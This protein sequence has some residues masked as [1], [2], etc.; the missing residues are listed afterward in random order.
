MIENDVISKLIK[1]NEILMFVRF[2]DDCLVISEKSTK[3][4]IFTE[5]NLKR[6]NMK[7][8]IENA[9][10]KSL[11]FLDTTLFYCHRTKKLELKHF[12]KSSKS[13]VM[14]NFRFSVAP[15]FQKANAVFSSVNRIMNSSTNPIDED[16]AIKNLSKKLGKLIP[17]KFYKR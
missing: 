6:D 16:K 10:N 1:S 2:V 4:K 7:Y 13:R 3:T 11:N 9:T 14:T 5:L 12:T 17:K 8:T 15:K